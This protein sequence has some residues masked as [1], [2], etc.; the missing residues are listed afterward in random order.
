[1]L[2]PDEIIGPKLAVQKARVE[3]VQRRQ[4]GPLLFSV[5]IL[6]TKERRPKGIITIKVKTIGNSVKLTPLRTI[7]P[8]YRLMTKVNYHSLKQVASGFVEDCQ[9]YGWSYT[10]SSGVA[11]GSSCPSECFYLDIDRS[12]QVAVVVRPASRAIPFPHG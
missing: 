11:S 5:S 2:E 6:R 7:D 4:R 9:P 12:V 8:K 10:L 1:M 3:I